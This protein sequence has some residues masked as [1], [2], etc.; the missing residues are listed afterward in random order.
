MQ[1]GDFLVDARLVRK[2]RNLGRE[3]RA[4]YF[5]IAEQRRDSLVEFDAVFLDD[6]WRAH[7]NLVGERFHRVRAVAQVNAEAFA[8]LLAH[9]EKVV[10]RAGDGCVQQR[11]KR[12]AVLVRLA[13][14]GNVRQAQCRGEGE[15]VSQREGFVRLSC[16]RD[17]RR[18]QGHVDLNRS[19]VAAEVAIVHKH[20]HMSARKAGG[21]CGTD[22][23]F[24][25]RKVTG[26]THADIEIAV[27][28]ALE[29]NRHFAPVRGRAS[30][31]VTCHAVHL[32]VTPKS[33]L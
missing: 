2:E 27:V 19:C 16:R 5:H 29:L 8:F 25:K 9:H 7:R 20:V 4:V 17:K 31:A 10:D 28:D 32:F 33:Q 14:V 13:N 11:E 18:E 22:R 12:V 30:F 6:D 21:E 1:A 26:Q 3:P 15:V 24:Q 23:I